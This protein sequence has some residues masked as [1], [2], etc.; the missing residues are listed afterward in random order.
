[1]HT[2]GLPQVASDR[3]V[4]LLFKDHL[5]SSSA[6]VDKDTSELV[7][8][9]GYQPFGATDYDY[10]PP[11]WQSHREDTHFTGKEEDVGTGLI[12][13]GARYY[14]P[15]L[16]R[17]VS[18]DPLT[19]HGWGGDANPYAYVGGRVVDRI[20]PVGLDGECYGAE[21]CPVPPGPDGGGGG[22]VIQIPIDFGDGGGDRR[23]GGRG[24]V[25]AWGGYAG[26]YPPPP[27]PPQAA[28][29]GS[30]ASGTAPTLYD[31]ASRSAVLSHPTGDYIRGV[32]DEVLDAVAEAFGPVTGHFVRRLLPAES[33]GPRNVDYLYGRV[34]VMAW[35]IPIEGT[36]LHAAGTGA[37]RSIIGRAAGGGSITYEALD[38]LGRPTGVTATL[39]E[40]LLER[41]QGTR[42]NQSIEP[43]GWNDVPQGN[44]ARGHLLGRQ[45]GGSG[46]IRQNL[47]TLE[48]TPANSPFM[49][50]LEGTVRAAVESG[51]VVEYSST[52]LYK[53]N[54]LIPR[55][56]TL[57][58]RGS[59]GFNLHVTVLNPFGF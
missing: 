56:I 47:V 42:A 13:F 25:S 15:H 29:P 39:T 14:S 33:E 6:M 45:L 49:R 2:A 41:G 10:R 20:D 16:Q 30:Y 7:E 48:Q 54:N 36:V 4:F 44:R 12:Y 53:G 31:F 37:L 5:G 40:E 26:S 17:F 58:A 22:I 24:G 23:R 57:Q 19:V 27:P 8:Y 32:R 34:S 51:Q 28:P 52:P 43:P 18:A 3:H 55:G 11:R 50:D 9:R 38:N 35:R 46:D 21:L 59:G 1:V